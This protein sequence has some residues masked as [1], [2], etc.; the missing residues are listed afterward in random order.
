MPLE[1]WLPGRSDTS[2]GAED[3][4]DVSPD[5]VQGQDSS[6]ASDPAHFEDEKLAA[7]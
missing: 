3:H 5:A 1:S 6:Q 2:S 4:L 7:E